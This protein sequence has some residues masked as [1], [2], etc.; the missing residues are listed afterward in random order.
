MPRKLLVTTAMVALPFAANAADLVTKA[1]PVSA[2]TRINWTGCFGGVNAGWGWGNYKQINDAEGS[3]GIGSGL[4]P[5]NVNASGPVLGGQVGCNYQTGSVVLGIEGLLS[6]AS[7]TDK[8]AGSLDAPKTDTLG[9]VTARLGFANVFGNEWMPYVKGG[10]AYRHEKDN[11]TGGHLTSF[12]QGG[13]TV[14]GGLEYM[15][16]PNWSVF[17]DYSYYKFGNH[18]DWT[19]GVCCTVAATANATISA[20]KVGVNFRLW[21]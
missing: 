11:W 14:G 18:T 19:T 3:G 16:A 20:V 4:N 6:A 17:V 9:S 8:G 7:I 1:P 12:S 5:A 10:Y 15:V 2:A 21:R 13:W